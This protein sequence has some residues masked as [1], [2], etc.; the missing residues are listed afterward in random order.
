MK[1]FLFQAVCLYLSCLSIQALAESTR[2]AIEATFISAIS[3][4]SEIYSHGGVAMKVIGGRYFLIGVGTTAAWPEN[5]AAEVVR[6]TRVGQVNAKAEISRLLGSSVEV[7][8]VLTANGSA[9]DADNLRT[10]I[11]D[12]SQHILLGVRPVGHWLSADGTVHYEAVAAELTN[13]KKGE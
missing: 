5:T 2:N 8:K 3:G 4:D 11:R 1:S 6:R 10:I 13:F 12:H 7:E 9:G